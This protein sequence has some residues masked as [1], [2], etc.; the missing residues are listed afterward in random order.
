MSQADSEAME[1][2]IHVLNDAVKNSVKLVGDEA[3]VKM[4]SQM[5]GRQSGPRARDE[6]FIQDFDP[7]GGKVTFLPKGLKL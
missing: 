2:A 7:Q 4:L 5:I 1:I 6:K 3:T